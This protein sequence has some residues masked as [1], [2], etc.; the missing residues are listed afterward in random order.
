MPKSERT[1]NV[2]FE[3]EE[4]ARD[5]IEIWEGLKVEAAMPERACVICG[6]VFVATKKSG[7][8]CG[9]KCRDENIRLKT[10]ES[11]R[12][13]RKINA[14]AN[15]AKERERYATDESFRNRII[16][17][18]RKWRMDH[19][20]L[21][22]EHDSKRNEKRR[23]ET[24]VKR[25]ATREERERLKE[26]KMEHRRLMENKRNRDK[27][28]SLSPEERRRINRE[29]WKKRKS[30]QLDYQINR[31]AGDAEFA[32]R[33]R[34]HVRGSQLKSKSRKALATMISNVGH[35]LKE[36]LND[37]GTRSSCPDRH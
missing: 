34:R 27:Y 36:K 3:V 37:I 18:R 21:A 29:N 25:E 12:R 7:K 26:Q 4:V 14:K 2:A 32:E 13:R 30:Y 23:S 31:R 1:T 24:A 5:D 22:R 20:E 35:D 19:P 16:E 17:R 10:N 28:R 15:R 33:C 8:T 6:V 11:A 9:S